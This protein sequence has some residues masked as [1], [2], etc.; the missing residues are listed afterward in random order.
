MAEGRPARKRD[1]E[2]ADV[3]PAPGCVADQAEGRDPRR[4][5]H[6]VVAGQLVRGDASAGH[7]LAGPEIVA[8]HRLELVGSVAIAVADHDLVTGEEMRPPTVGQLDAAVLAERLDTGEHEVSR[9]GAQR[10]GQQRSHRRDRDATGGEGAFRS[11]HPFEYQEL[12]SR[13]RC[14]RH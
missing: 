8:E 7:E 12:N 9:R 4:H 5:R 6:P 1:R 11:R 2:V 3:Q 14:R 13:H 10:A